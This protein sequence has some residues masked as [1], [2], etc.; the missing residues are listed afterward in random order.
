M[1]PSLQASLFANYH[2]L[3]KAHDL[4][5]HSSSVDDRGA[6]YTRREVVDCMLD[7]SGYTIDKPLKSFRLLEP[8]CGGGEF[9]VA[10]VERLLAS[11]QRRPSV[12]TIK[13]CIRAVEL[14]RASFEKATLAVRSLLSSFG[15]SENE[16]QELSDCWLIHEDFLLCA[17]EGKFDLVVGNPPYVRQER[18]NSA[19]LAEYKRRYATLYD[20]ADLYVLFIERGLELLSE[21]GQLCFICAD[22]W[23]KNK[24]GRPL[25]EYVS[26]G[27]G[28]K[29]YMDMTHIDAFQSEVVAYPAI[30]LIQRNYVGPTVIAH[31]KRV[32]NLPEISFESVPTSTTRQ[33]SVASDQGHQFRQAYGVVN[34]SEPWLLGASD[35]LQLVRRL[36]EKFPTIEEDGCKVGIGVATGADKAFIGPYDELPVEQSRKLPLVMT[37]DIVTGRVEWKGYGVVNPFEEDGSLAQLSTYPKFAAYL[38]QRKDLITKR[39]VAQ[40]DP[41]RW[42]RTIDRITPA[43]AR[44]PKL[45]IPDIKGR[46]LVAYD[47]GHLYPH[48]NLYFVVSSTWDLEALQALLMSD[49]ARL[50]VATY[51]TKMRG[52]FLRFQAQYLRRIRV[53]SYASIKTQD[54]NMLIAAARSLDRTKANEA[55]ARVYGIDDE[56]AILLSEHFETP[57]RAEV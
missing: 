40:K 9:L 15:Y 12:K 55:A 56:E 1:P 49:V 16:Q 10:A 54:R 39:H 22:R 37:R 44:Q 23:M 41:V 38:A 18:I 34:G 4:L 47:P 28:L 6:I 14:H 51:S 50:F 32:E 24:Y 2:A 46:A 30:T 45:L 13:N 33:N 17:L 48:H 29:A 25:R 27:F 42:Y 5:A 11:E 36:E 21:K 7:W 8:S 43:L 3:Q 57:S 35:L 19:L 53:P 31:A 20:R 26:N 52:G